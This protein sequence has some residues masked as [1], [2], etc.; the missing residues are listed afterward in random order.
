MFS[1]IV[2]TWLLRVLVG[3]AAIGLFLLYSELRNASKKEAMWSGSIARESLIVPSQV[4]PRDG[5][6]KFSALRAFHLAQN[7]A[8]SVALGDAGAAVRADNVKGRANLLKIG[9]DCGG[10]LR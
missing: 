9:L 1:Q 6:E 5:G 3:L 8:A 7:Q 4:T 2:Q 10:A